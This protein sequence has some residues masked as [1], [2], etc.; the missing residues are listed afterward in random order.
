VRHRLMMRSGVVALAVIWA[1][2]GYTSPADDR[3][4]AEIST[5]PYV[6]RYPLKASSNNRYL[7]DQNNI[8]FMIVGDS[9]H[10][11]IGR[12]SKSDAEFYMA[13]RQRYGINT[14]WVELLCNNKTACNSDGTT[15]DGIPPFTVTGDI[16][17]P[18]PAYFQRVDDMLQIAAIHG[19][20][21]LLDAVET[22]GWL[23]TFKANGPERAATFGRYLGN[24]YKDFPNII[25]M[26]GNDFQTWTNPTDDAVVLA[27]EKG[28]GSVDPS[29]IHTTELNYPT[30]GS[31]IDVRWEPLIQLDG[32]YTYY[33][34][35]A[36]ILKEYNRPNFRPVFMEEANYEFE[37]NSNT[38]GGSPAN[39]R[40]QEYW[41]MLSGATGQ[42]YGSAYT[43][44][45]PS[46]WRSKLDT[47][48]IIQLSYMKNLFAM[49]KWYDLVPD[50]T[51]TLVID[52]YG[53]PAPFGTGSVTTDSYATAARTSDGALAIVYVPTIRT[54]RVDM[55]K[56]AGTTVARWY[57]RALANLLT[58]VARQ[59]QTPASG[60]S[61]HLATI[62]LVMGTGL[63][64][65]K[66]TRGQSLQIESI[67]A[68]AFRWSICGGDSQP[69]ACRC[70]PVAPA[71]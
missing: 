32:A 34:T 9:P 29:H 45:L 68:L 6:P 30:S 24:R 64:F 33:P 28:I 42:L 65:S 40:R 66:Q 55:S 2:G 10:S 58:L 12:M 67:G 36:Q 25:W 60:N 71:C 59:D 44:K 1:L 17:T 56:L 53:T 49:R 54:I 19:I 7:V 35:Y 39:L 41:T 61:S 8:P 23:D 11:L 22:D 57:D 5:R 52:G 37:H 13:N 47:P 26:Y 62:T 48:G 38:D 3:A 21:V 46:G 27:V 4:T 63:S 18:N 43:W 51:H 69:P 20:T 16:S 31:L 50:Q 15:F 70:P 14:L